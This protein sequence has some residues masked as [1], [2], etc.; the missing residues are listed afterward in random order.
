MFLPER[1]DNA[2]LKAAGLKAGEPPDII[3]ASSSW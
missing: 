3:L 1:A 2:G